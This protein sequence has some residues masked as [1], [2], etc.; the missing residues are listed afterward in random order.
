MGLDPV[1]AG[2]LAKMAA[3]GHQPVHELPVAEARR[4]F[5]DG[6]R[7]LLGEEHAPV[8]LRR[9]HDEAL[10]RGTVVRCYHPREAGPL[11]TVLFCHGGGWVLGDLDSHDELCRHLAASLPAVVVAVDYRR[12]PEHPHPAA[13]QDCWAALQWCADEIG[14]LGRDPARLVVAGDSAGGSLAAV[15][16]QRATARGGPVLAAQALLYPSVDCATDRPSY[17]ENADGC[18]LTTEAMAWFVRSYLPAPRDRSLPDAGPWHAADLA[19][20]PPAVVATAEFDPLRDEGDAYADRLA[21]AEVPVRHLRF[22]VLAHGFAVGFPGV[23]PEAA[24]ARDAV[25]TALGAILRC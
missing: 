18:F 2:V 3:A 17:T 16:A 14:A 19:G 15:L 22:P 12:A 1:L 20:L 8:P 21:R 5:R 7:A 11:P 10:P 13:L 4:Q 9:V 6:T 24:A 23:V 25:I